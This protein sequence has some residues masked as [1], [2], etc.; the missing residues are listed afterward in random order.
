MNIVRGK[1]IRF[2]RASTFASIVEGYVVTQ[3]L[4]KNQCLVT[5]N[6]GGIVRKEVYITLRE[7][8]SPLIGQKAFKYRRLRI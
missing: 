5:T 7:V 1:C 8:L 3:Q 2:L 4:N 6:R